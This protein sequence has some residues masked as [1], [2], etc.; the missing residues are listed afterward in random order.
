M[1]HYAKIRIIAITALCLVPV[2]NSSTAFTTATKD[3]PTIKFLTPINKAPEND[4]FEYKDVTNLSGEIAYSEY[5]K[6]S[7]EKSA[8]FIVV[9]TIKNGVQAHVISLPVED[10]SMSLFDIQLSPNGR[11]VLFKIGI[12]GIEDDGST[13]QSFKLFYWDLKTK[14]VLSVPSERLTFRKA[15]WSLS[16]RYITYCLGNVD[17]NWLNARPHKPLR[18]FTYDI[19]TKQTHF[20]G[21]GVERWIWTKT[22]ELLYSQTELDHERKQNQSNRLKS[23]V[24][25]LDNVYLS[26]ATGDTNT[27][28]VKEGRPLAVS[29]DGSKILFSTTYDPELPKNEKTKPKLISYYYLCIYDI[30]QQ[31]LL[32]LKNIRGNFT[33]ERFL[34]DSQLLLSRFSYSNLVQ[35]NPLSIKEYD[36]S[37]GQTKQL[38]KVPVK[39]ESVSTYEPLF[40]SFWLSKD[41]NAFVFKSSP[42][43]KK[44]ASDRPGYERYDMPVLLNLVNLK[45]GET[46]I[47][48]ESHFIGNFSFGP[49]FE[50]ES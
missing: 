37:T 21:Y 19:Q 31:K 45:T 5:G 39:Y 40:N 32:P 29:A 28:I 1:K 48:C 38:A 24:S 17:S 46:S 23:N 13:Y 9:R 34:S 20:I 49:I 42:M 15:S 26:S 10:F 8:D 41:E 4:P 25:E 14:K 11:Y 50:R 22:N 16:S 27:L 43:G 33:D 30:K 3:K 12:S 35:I 6:I 44:I 2:V 7:D 47:I 36:I 18:L